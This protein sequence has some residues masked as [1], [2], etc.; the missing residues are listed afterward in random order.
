MESI[1]VLVASL[2]VFSFSALALG[3]FRWMDEAHVLT[4]RSQSCFLDALRFS[5]FL[6]QDSQ[7]LAVRDG[8]LVLDHVVD[9]SKVPTAYARISA[10]SSVFISCGPVYAGSDLNYEA[11]VLRYAY[12]QGHGIVP[13]IVKTCPRRS[14]G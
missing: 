12:W 4:A 9:C 8:P 1:D 13:V 6:I 14:G 5:D 3:T 11:T 2:V 7:G 10:V